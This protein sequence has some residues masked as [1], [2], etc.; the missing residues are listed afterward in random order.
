MERLAKVLGWTAII[1]AVTVGLTLLRG[2]V[3]VILWH[4]FVV[5][6]FPVPYLNV[7]QM[8]GLSVVVTFL[9]YQYDARKR[10]DEDKPI[11]ERFT[12]LAIVGVATYM[13]TLGI[14]AIIHIWVP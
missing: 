6:L 4:W 1:V 10:D 5:P 11:G 2:A 9:T 14:A 13:L 12:E 3:A 7:G 8:I